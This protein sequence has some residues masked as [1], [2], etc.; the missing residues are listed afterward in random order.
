MM[1]QFPMWILRAFFGCIFGLAINTAAHATVLIDEN[2]QSHDAGT[3]IDT[4]G[5]NL[6]AETGGPPIIREESPGVPGTN[7]YIVTS[8]LNNQP[9]RY[10][11]PFVNPGFFSGTTLTF[12]AD[13]WDPLIN[14]NPGQLSTFPRAV[15]GIYQYPNSHQSAM[16]PYFGLETND[17]NPDDD[18]TT[19]EWVVSGENF[20][21][22]PD[23]TP[24]M[25]GPTLDQGTWYSVKSEWNLGAKTMNLLVKHRDLDEPFTTI[26]SGVTLGFDDPNQNMAALDAFQIRML[27]GTRMD[28]F[29]VEYDAVMAPGVAGDY[30]KDGVVDAADYVIWRNNLGTNFQLQNEVSGVTP[31]QVTQEDYDAWRARFGNTSGS[32]ASILSGS[33]VPE[34]S[35]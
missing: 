30:N 27:R 35:G 23:P 18:P 24:Q 32:G 8:T 5:W 28:N 4:I 33:S 26:F 19:G 6:V 25:F 7:K 16:P 14:E 21:N 20:G 13:V 34:P 22:P 2:F 15:M 9:A 12:T 31:G 17:S 10:E 3:T 1:R 11:L 29:K